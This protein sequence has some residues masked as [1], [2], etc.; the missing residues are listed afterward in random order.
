MEHSQEQVS[1]FFSCIFPL[2]DL[3]RQAR[4]LKHFPL[5]PPPQL[6]SLH[7]VETHGSHE[8]WE[9]RS[10]AYKPSVLVHAVFRSRS[11]SSCNAQSSEVHWWDYGGP[12]VLLVQRWPSD[13]GNSSDTEGILV[14]ESVATLDS[15]PFRLYCAS[16]NHALKPSLVPT[17]PLNPFM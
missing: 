8:N 17:G 15:R 10:V 2:C 13:S 1:F 9:L 16:K 5:L 6:Y 14:L 4:V 11:S 7:R 12:R 3:G